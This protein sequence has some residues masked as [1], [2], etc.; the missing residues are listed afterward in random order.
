[1]LNLCSESNLILNSA[2]ILLSLIDKHKESEIV[3]SISRNGL[4]KSFLVFW[5]LECRNIVK[6]CGCIFAPERQ[7]DVK[8]VCTLKFDQINGNVQKRNSTNVSRKSVNGM[9]KKIYI[10]LRFKYK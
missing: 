8:N 3:I 2:E 9:R 1:M 7:W 5:T 4:L 6:K 10:Y